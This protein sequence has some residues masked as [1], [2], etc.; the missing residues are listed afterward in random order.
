MLE[1]KRIQDLSFRSKF[2]IFIVYIFIFF[3]S[4][5]IILLY[6]SPPCYRITDEDVEWAESPYG[7]PIKKADSDVILIDGE[8]IHWPD[9]LSDAEEKN[10]YGT[11]WKR[12]DTD[13]DGMDDG[14]EVH[15]R[16]WDPQR[17]KWTLDPLVPDAFENPDGDGFDANHD[18]EISEEEALFNLREYCGGVLYDFEK[19]CFDESDPIFGGLSPVHNASE[20]AILGGFNLFD[21][22]DYRAPYI[23]INPSDRKYDVVVACYAYSPPKYP[24]ITSNP[25]E[26]DSDKDGMDDGWETHYHRE[27]NRLFFHPDGSLRVMDTI[28]LSDLEMKMY[29]FENNDHSIEDIQSNITRYPPL[30]PILPYDPDIDLDLFPIHHYEAK[31]RTIWIYRPDGLTSLE[32][33]GYGTSPLLWDTDGDSFY[34]TMN[35][36]FYDLGDAVEVL[37][38]EYS[39]MDRSRSSKILQKFP[40]IGPYSKISILS[41]SFSQ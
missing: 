35:E 2:I 41:H 23:W 18:G 33:Y 11:D 1:G 6:T 22:P 20:I 7:A 30:S 38:P 37:T 15:Y 12:P 40:W 10:E 3:F 16:K 4:L 9:R 28:V 26:F 19:E 32:E 17:M 27:L 39:N 21:D 14:W 8:Y 31:N 29:G 25:S 13:G 24:I 5:T 34:D 36:R